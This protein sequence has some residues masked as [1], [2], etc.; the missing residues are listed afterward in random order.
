MKRGTKNLALFLVPY[1]ALKIFSEIH[2][3]MA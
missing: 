2:N 3:L 1:L